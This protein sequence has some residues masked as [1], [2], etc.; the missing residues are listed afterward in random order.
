MTLRPVGCLQV[1]H[2]DAAQRLNPVIKA[3]WRLCAGDESIR[4]SH[5]F[6]GRFENVYVPLDRVPDLRTVITAIH[7]AAREIPGGEPQAFRSGFWF[8]EMQPGQRTLPHNH[9]EDDELL[10]AVY[11]VDVPPDSGDLLVCEE[12]AVTRI[13]PEAG[14]FVLFSPHL[15]HEVTRNNS[16][17][18]RLSVAFNLGSPAPG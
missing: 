1:G 8:N 13:T 10:S 3:A 6:A 16:N 17:Q 9:E 4:R 15:D 5:F 14:M 11:Y 7:V 18:T 12:G 2:F